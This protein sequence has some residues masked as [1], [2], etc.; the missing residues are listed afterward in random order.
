MSV[1]PAMP[2]VD[3]MTTT[4]LFDTG[5]DLGAEHLAEI[6]RRFDPLTQRH[7]PDGVP[8]RGARCLDVGSGAGSITALL[9]ELAG[10]DGEV[11]A[12]DLDTTRLTGM[13]K[14]VTVHQH[15]VGRGLPVDG[16]FDLVHARLLM[17][18]L[19]ERA[20]VLADLVAT[21][22]PGGWLLLGDLSDRPLHV[23]STPDL[24][25]A[26][27][28][29]RMMYLSHEV[30]SPARGLSFTWAHQAAGRLLEHGLVDVEGF[31]HGSIDVGGGPGCALHANLNR[32]AEPALLAA[33]ATPQEL[34]DYRQ[35][36]GDPRFRAWSYSFVGTR[37]RRPA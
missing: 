23:V 15:D 21:L 8:G 37:G 14:T 34:A 5:S 19:P 3:G 7:L 25:S 11:H 36:M 28:F 26:D 12:V 31:E 29:R 17:P 9:A 2:R 10:P 4:Y 30:V 33:G 20:E 27:L 13:P 16:P 1:H 22:A 35:L 18:H 32:Q 6:E 24:A